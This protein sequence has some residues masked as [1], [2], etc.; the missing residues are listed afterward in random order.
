MAIG[1]ENKI[2]FKVVAWIILLENVHTLQNTTFLYTLVQNLTSLCLY[3]IMHNTVTIFVVQYNAQH[4][5]NI[6]SDNGQK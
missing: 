6:C 3:G 5:Y 2:K 1:I 4:S